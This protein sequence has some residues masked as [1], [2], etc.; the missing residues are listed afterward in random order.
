MYMR[1]L[2]VALASTCCRTSRQ[3]QSNVRVLGLQRPLFVL[4][5]AAVALYCW[6]RSRAW[7]GLALGLVAG[8]AA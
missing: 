5:V 8:G 6:Y 4:L 1:F 3:R 2:A 7:L